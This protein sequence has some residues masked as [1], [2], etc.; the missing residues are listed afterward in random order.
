MVSPAGEVD[1]IADFALAAH[2][3]AGAFVTLHMVTGA[4]ALR[5]VSQWVDPTTAQELAAYAAW[6]M[7]SAYQGVGTPELLSSSDL[8]AIRSRPLPA[9]DEIAAQAVAA[10]DAHVIKLADV[11][12]T[13]EQ[14]SGDPLYRYL[15]ANVVGL[16]SSV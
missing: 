13:E 3:T 1:A 10:T 4:R 11:A 12:L 16:G 2:A 6:A 9:R 8:D 15:A 7:A 14:R 5:V